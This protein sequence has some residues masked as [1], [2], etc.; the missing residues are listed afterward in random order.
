MI[1]GSRRELIVLRTGASRYFD[2]AYFVLRREIEAGG[3]SRTDILR[4]ANRILEENIPQ[5][6]V[7]RRGR[8]VSA[9]WFFVGV[10]CGVGAALAFV[11]FSG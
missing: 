9:L 7:S 1:K 8:G 6:R 2:E 5:A 4:E 10:I 11:L 3:R